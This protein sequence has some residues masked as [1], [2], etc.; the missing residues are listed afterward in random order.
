MSVFDEKAGPEHHKYLYFH[1]LTPLKE[2]LFTLNFGLYLLKEKEM[3]G[4]KE[5]NYKSQRK[6][7]NK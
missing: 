1:H 7:I 3:G 6:H 5:V 2:T 4:P